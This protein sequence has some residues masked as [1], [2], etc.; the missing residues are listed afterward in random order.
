MHP[1]FQRPG[2]S[3]RG[4]ARSLQRSAHPHLR[5]A[6]C[7][8]PRPLALDAPLPPP[9]SARAPRPPPR[10][11]RRPSC[12]PFSSC[13]RLSVAAAKLALG[14]TCNVMVMMW[15]P[16]AGAGTQR[17]ELKREPTEL[18]PYSGCGSKIS[19]SRSERRILSEPM[20]MTMSMSMSIGPCPCACACLAVCVKQ[21]AP[22]AMWPV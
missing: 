14:H 4:P 11:P 12:P 13:S 22:L 21:S 15:R 8:P 20:S 5:R 19:T 10:P 7:A 18:S 16:S 6:T 3:A 2:S 17:V 9:S 1:A